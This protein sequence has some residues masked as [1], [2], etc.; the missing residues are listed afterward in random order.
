MDKSNN[1]K[2]NKI[3]IAIKVILI[4]IIILLLIHNCT[5]LKQNNEYKNKDPNGNGDLIEIE[6]NK[7]QC[8]PVAIVKLSFVQESFNIKKGDTQKLIVLVNP[9]FLASSELTWESS[10]ESIATV[11]NNGVVTG[12]KNGQVTITVTSSNGVSTTCVVNVVLDS[13]VVNKII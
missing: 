2:N 1:S 13:I 12:L 3:D 4:V 10:D 9:S 7:D 5:L 6:C 11:D 8:K